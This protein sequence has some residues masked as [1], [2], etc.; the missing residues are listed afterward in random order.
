MPPGKRNQKNKIVSDNAKSDFQASETGSQSQDSAEEPDSGG[1]PLE[2][3]TT[4]LERVSASHRAFSR[5]VS[6]SALVG[7]LAGACGGVAGSVFVYPWYQEHFLEKNDTGAIIQ[8]D[9]VV[10][11]EQSSIIDAVERA[12]SAVVSIVVSKDLPKFE[13]FGSPFD[14]FVV[15]SGETELQRVGAG[16]GFII[17]EDGMIVT[18][19]HVVEDTAA[20]YTVITND[21]EKFSAKVLAVDPFNDLAVVKIEKSGLPI[22]VLGDSDKL[23]L[24]QRVIAIGNALGE[25]QNTVTTG[26]VSGI[27]RSITAT[28]LAQTE[29]LSELIQTDAA[30][31]PGNSGGPLV[32][33]EG[34]VIGV[35]TAVSSE[36]QLIGFAIPINQVRKVIDDVKKYGRVR[37]PFLG[38]RYTIVT[39][40]FAKENNLPKD[41][42][43]LV[44][45]G[46]SQDEPAVVPGSPADKAGLEAGDIIL[47][48]SGKQITQDAQLA[49]QLRD[50]NPGDRVS[51]KILR[52]TEEKTLSATLGEAQ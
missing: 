10:L 36:A 51:M 44:V 41:Y 11:D 47:E 18:N 2:N 40:S 50:Y 6:T 32:N 33:L 45:Q 52:G 24:G 4:D 9:R 37:R 30:I 27:G 12:N 43:V 35:N 28:G 1:N 22:A 19:K 5:A 3:L 39:E 25:F 34:E 16:S 8:R 42:G 14:G 29:K 26:V 49:D 17:S 15:P 21:N 48:L 38:V 31:N 46:A 20:E 7:L 23:K 13:Q